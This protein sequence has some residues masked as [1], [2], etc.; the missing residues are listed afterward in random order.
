[1]YWSYKVFPLWFYS[2]KQLFL[3]E[4]LQIL[5]YSHHAYSYNKHIT[6]KMHLIKYN[7]KHESPCLG[8]RVPS[9]GGLLEQKNISPTF[10]QSVR[11]VFHIVI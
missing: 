5:C 8:S 4:D 11:L 1:M 2:S 3:V 6:Q 9:L 7:D 10:Y